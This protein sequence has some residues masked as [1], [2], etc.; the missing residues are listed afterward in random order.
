MALTRAEAIDLAVRR[1]VAATGSDAHWIIGEADARAVRA[2]YRA[3]CRT[4]DVRDNV[5]HMHYDGHS[6]R[7]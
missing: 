2:H 5:V 7:I 3:V 1:H 6:L 4:Y